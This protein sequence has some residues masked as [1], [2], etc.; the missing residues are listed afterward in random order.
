MITLFATFYL[1]FAKDGKEFETRV[2]IF[3]IAVFLDVILFSLAGINH[4]IGG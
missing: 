1:G 2:A 4:V 3:L